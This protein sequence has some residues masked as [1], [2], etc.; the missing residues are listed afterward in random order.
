MGRDYVIVVLPET[1]NEILLMILLLVGI[2]TWVY[3]WRNERRRKAAIVEL[4]EVTTKFQKLYDGKVQCR[5][6]Q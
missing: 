6:E 3:Q 5:E 2:S 1:I 4:E